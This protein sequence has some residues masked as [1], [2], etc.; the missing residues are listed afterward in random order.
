MAAAKGGLYNKLQIFTDLDQSS[1]K[2][3]LVTAIPQAG[4]LVSEANGL[5]EK[6]Q[7]LLSGQ[8]NLTVF[9]TNIRCSSIMLRSV[10]CVSLQT[11]GIKLNGFNLLYKGLEM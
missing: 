1:Y 6:A 2:Q 3:E 10:D 11:D 8:S 5:L 7:V 9:S 4:I